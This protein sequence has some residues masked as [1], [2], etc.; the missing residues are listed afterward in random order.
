MSDRPDNPLRS[1][2]PACEPPPARA[3]AGA[4]P[5]VSAGLGAAAPPSVPANPAAKGRRDTSGHAPGGGTSFGARGP[6]YLLGVLGRGWRRLAAGL[7]GRRFVEAHERLRH[8]D[9]RSL[10]R[11]VR[12]GVGGGLLLVGLG[13]GWL[14]GPGGFVGVIGAALLAT[15]WR[16]LAVWLDRA[17]IAGWR[18]W[19]AWQRIT[20]VQRA[21]LAI[22]CTAVVATA[23]YLLATSLVR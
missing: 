9:R 14:P 7:P 6:R 22:G 8:S 2:P 1:S 5:A 19:V 21:I 12:M 13:I 10:G 20:G 11:L 16:A 4:S 17:E 23:A 3:R 15:E 18:T